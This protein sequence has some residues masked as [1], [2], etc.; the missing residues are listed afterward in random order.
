VSLLSCN[1]NSFEACE[2][3]PTPNGCR[4]KAQKVDYAGKV[5]FWGCLETSSGNGCR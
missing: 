3:P 1:S 5:P 4:K 2:T